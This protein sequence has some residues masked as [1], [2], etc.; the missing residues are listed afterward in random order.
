MKSSTGEKNIVLQKI[1]NASIYLQKVIRADADGDFYNDV[2][3]NREWI[4]G[5]FS[6]DQIVGLCSVRK[7]S[8][9]FLYVYIFPE[10]RNRGYGFLAARVA[11][12]HLSTSETITIG[13]AYDSKNHIAGRFAENCGFIN[14][15]STSVMA[16]LG[17]RFDNPVLP[18][19]KYR[20]EDFSEAYTLSAEAF[21]V[22]RVETGHDPDS[23]PYA[24]DEEARQYCLDT[25]D[26]RYVYVV[27]NEI[28][29]CANIDGAEIDN[30]AIAIPHQGKGYGRAFVKFL[31]NEILDKDMGEPFL[32]CL[33][34][35]KKARQL[36]D[37][38][39]FTETACN[40]YA[41]KTIR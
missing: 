36:Y 29:G 37:S 34:V 5:V 32:Y 20:D 35:N 9:A 30:I 6:E 12:E 10:Y 3:Q 24:A 22:M 15:F 2:V 17:K 13:T 14:K 23:V 26:G 40:V 8:E 4:Y 7:G 18:I 31:V 41:V 16:Y 33:G 39:G 11:E 21:H 27:N 38:L 19:R 25:A 28:I 1:P